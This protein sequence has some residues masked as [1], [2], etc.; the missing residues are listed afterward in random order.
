MFIVDLSWNFF[1]DFKP[2][3]KHNEPMLSA[4]KHSCKVKIHKLFFIT[5]TSVEVD[6]VFQP[7]ELIEQQNTMDVGE[8][9]S[10]ELSK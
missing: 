4:V 10:L 1:W 5:L 9:Q 3:E 8:R 2:P 6:V 7:W